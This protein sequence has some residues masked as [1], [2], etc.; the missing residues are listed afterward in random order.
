[1]A[2]AVEISLRDMDE[3]LSRQG[4]S[5]IPNLPR[6]REV[7]YGK[8]VGANLCLRVYTSIEGGSSRGVGE[9]A[10]RTV[11]VARVEGEV[12]LVG[13]DRRVHRVEGWRKNLQSRLDGWA[14]QL[15]PACPKCGLP[16]VKRRSKRGPFWG[17]SNYPVCRSVTPVVTVPI[18]HR[19]AFDVHLASVVDSDE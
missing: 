3:F 1:M 19:E 9:D 11:L 2:T 10:I 16:T 4:F 7:V 12:K 18:Q 13:S 14:E 5:V 6:T 17:C 8:V 15:G